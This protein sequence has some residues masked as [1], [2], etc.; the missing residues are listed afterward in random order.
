[1]KKGWRHFAARQKALLI[2][3]ENH[4]GTK[5]L[6][7]LLTGRWHAPPARMGARGI[8]D[9]SRVEVSDANRLPLNGCLQL[10]TCVSNAPPLSTDVEISTTSQRMAV[11]FNFLWSARFFLSFTYPFYGCSITPQNPH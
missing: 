2:D 10:Q 4:W 6:G 7:D 1:M 8:G 9:R 11:D 3:A 5:V